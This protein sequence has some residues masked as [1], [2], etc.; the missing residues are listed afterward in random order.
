M[1]TR[2]SAAEPQDEAQLCRKRKRGM[3][4]DEPRASRSGMPP[5]MRIRIGAERPSPI[6]D[7]I[8][9]E[10]HRAFMAWLGAKR[11]IRSPM[12]VDIWTCN[13]AKRW[14]IATRTSKLK[15]KGMK[16]VPVARGPLMEAALRMFVK[17]TPEFAPM[18][19]TMA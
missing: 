5:T 6:P 1:R 13:T 12:A 14:S 16:R 18:R 9:P 10:A 11:S 8:T 4:E 7:I 15:A 2:S 19:S 17:E 3:Q